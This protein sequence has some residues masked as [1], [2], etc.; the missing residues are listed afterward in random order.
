VRKARRAFVVVLAIGLGLFLAVP[1]EDIPETA[2]DESETAACESTPLF[3]IVLP[4][5]AAPKA[6]DVRGAAD[7]RYD[8]LSALTLTRVNGK[9]ATRSPNAGESLALLSTL[10]C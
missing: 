8:S 10:R 3:S 5:A 9:D 1:A 4:R 2:F 6:R 7:L